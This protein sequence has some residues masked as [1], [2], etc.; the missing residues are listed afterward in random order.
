V[1]DLRHHIG[2]RIDDEPQFAVEVGTVQRERPA[3]QL[4]ASIARG[5]V[6]ELETAQL[7]RNARPQFAGVRQIG[8]EHVPFSRVRISSIHGC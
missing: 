7:A 3:P 1:L 8:F 2:F 5:D 4:A 6:H